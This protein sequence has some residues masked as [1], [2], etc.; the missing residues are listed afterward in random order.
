[1]WLLAQKVVLDKDNMLKRKWQ[2]SQDYYFCGA[3]ETCDHL[4]FACLIPKVIWGGL[5]CCFH[6]GDRLSSLEQFWLWIDKVVPRGE[7]FHMVGLAVICWAIWKAR[8][9]K[10]F[11]KKV[12]KNH[13][14]ILFSVCSF[15]RYWSGL[16]SE[17][18]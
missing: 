4:F 18:N 8:N 6:Q 14:E 15:I 3:P 13:G 11:E 7:N 16:F 12:I 5:A 2:G 10:C 1:M 17:D 9:R